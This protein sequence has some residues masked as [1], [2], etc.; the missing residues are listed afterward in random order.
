MS[1]ETEAT[2]TTTTSGDG[3]EETKAAVTYYQ[4]INYYLKL[5]C[6]MGYG[7]GGRSGRRG[8]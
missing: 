2:T 3:D 5:T 8:K 1:T 7:I 6:D 4:H